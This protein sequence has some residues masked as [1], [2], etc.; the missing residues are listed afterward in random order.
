MRSPR[1][2]LT[3]VALAAAVVSALPGGTASAAATAGP[4]VGGVSLAPA[5]V[6]R[7]V[8][9]R[10]VDL[11]FTVSNNEAQPVWIALSVNELSQ[12]PDGAFIYG[13]PS[14]LRVE[15]TEVLLAPGRS[16]PVRVIGELPAGAPALYAG[17][18]AEPRREQTPTAGDVRVRTRL[19]ALL[20]LTTPGAHRRAVEVTDVTLSPTADKG[21]FRVGAMLRNTGEV[22][23]RPRGSVEIAQLG[24]SVLGTATLTGAVILPGAARRL[25]GGMWTAPPEVDR[26]VRLDAVITEPPATGSRTVDLD[27]VQRDTAPPVVPGGNLGELGGD[28]PGGAPWLVWLAVAL[29]LLMTAL[30]AWHR[31]R[32]GLQTST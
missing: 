5:V 14:P 16:A 21:T 7:E 6:E 17:L 30:L 1:R 4:N 25:D 9:R 11:S 27:Q 24:G 26:T 18:L 23:V 2:L 8:A 3:T 12:S 13:A 28:G 19:A 32:R 10:A 20:L 31:T 22:H 15:P 29:L